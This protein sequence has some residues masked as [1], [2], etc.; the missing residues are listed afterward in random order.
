ML[1][2]RTGCSPGHRRDSG[3]STGKGPGRAES[4]V[5]A[6]ARVACETQ[7]RGSDLRGLQLRSWAAGA[8]GRG[9]KVSLAASRA[10]IGFRGQGPVVGPKGAALGAGGQLAAR[11]RAHGKRRGGAVRHRSQ[12]GPGPGQAAPPGR[13][14]WSRRRG[15]D[16]AFCERSAAAPAPPHPRAPRPAWREEESRLLTEE[17][18]QPRAARVGALPGRGAEK[19]GA[20][21]RGARAGPSQPR[22]SACPPPANQACPPLPEAPGRRCQ[23]ET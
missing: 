1:P 19:R 8:A 17:A 22:G 10:L 12:P 6:A 20:G 13:L 16:R 4:G 5:G 11:G 7:S 3:R 2:P 14:S 9:P 15:G 21:S 18:R 23:Q